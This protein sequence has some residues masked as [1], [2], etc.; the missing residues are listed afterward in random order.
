MTPVRRARAAAAATIMWMVAVAAPAWAAATIVIDE[1]PPSDPYF[2]ST[3]DGNVVVRGTVTA[4]D[5]KRIEDL[6]FAFTPP[7]EEGGACASTLVNE[8]G[9]VSISEDGKSATFELVISAPCNR[10]HDVAATVTHKDPLLL[11][12]ARPGPQTTKPVNF[13]IAV[14][15]ARVEGVKATYDPEAKK[16]KLTWSRNAEPDIVGYRVERN[17]PG[18]DG[19][20]PLG[21]VTSDL[22]FTDTLAVDE[23]HRYRVV[24]IRSGPDA[25]VREVPGQPSDIV[26]AGPDRPEPTVPDTTLVR[27]PPPGANSAAGRAG[28]GGSGA[29]GGSG[30]GAAPRGSRGPVTTIDNGF[31][32]NLPFDP[33][34]T[35]TIPA[36]PSP[37]P[38]EDAAVLAIDDDRASEDDRRATL[39]PIAGGLALMMGAVHLRLLSKRAGEPELPIYATSAPRR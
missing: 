35:T 16:V 13:A 7:L 25:K 14:P 6:S 28:R 1:P 23:E 4:D 8:P 34:Q 12:V 32:Q 33:S 27:P 38:P 11:G 36:S 2:R 31:D 19:F 20:E 26:T 22:S 17:P 37:V 24:A 10:R 9:A 18:P 29:S 30:N 5:D 15:P 3:E 39:A 21:S